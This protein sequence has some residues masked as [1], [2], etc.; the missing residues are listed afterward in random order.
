MP[1][2]VDHD[3][4]RSE[5]ADA[6]LSIA[7]RAGIGTVTIRAVAEEAGWSTGVLIHYFGNRRAMLAGAL[8]RAAEISGQRHMEIAQEG[9]ATTRLE[10]ALAEALPLDDRRLALGRVFVFFYAEAAADD[11]MRSEIEGYLGVWRKFVAGAIRAGQKQ[12][13]IDPGIDPLATATHLVALT[14]GL[15]MHALF[16]PAVMAEIRN[17][18]P[19]GT[20]IA[21]LAPAGPAT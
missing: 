18:P 15:S 10:R 17:R 4:R 12:G 9:D 6:V 2:V 7:A 20:W 11:R 19:V 13:R 3:Q 5:I 14:D 1:K 21:R 16:D 8:R